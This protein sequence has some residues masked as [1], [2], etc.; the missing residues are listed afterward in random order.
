MINASIL[1]PK[2]VTVDA[3]GRKYIIRNGKPQNNQ[4]KTFFDNL[5][6]KKEYK[7]FVEDCIR[8]SE[9]K[10][11]D[12]LI[13]LTYD[14][15]LEWEK[16]NSEWIA[17]YGEEKYSLKESKL[18]Y[19]INGYIWG[20]ITLNDRLLSVA[21]SRMQTELELGMDD[22]I[23]K[24]SC[25]DMKQFNTKMEPRYAYVRI[26]MNKKKIK[27]YYSKTKEEYFAYSFD[28]SYEGIPVCKI[29][30]FKDYLSLR[31]EFNGLYLKPVSILAKYGYNVSSSLSASKRQAILKM[32]MDQNIMSWNQIIEHLQFL[33]NMHSGL[34][35][36]HAV[37]LWNEDY[38]FVLDY[39]KKK[40]NR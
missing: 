18:R 2:A 31:E 16:K 3:N 30:E 8:F 32:I 11:D 14:G 22:M 39:Y 38:E 37:E 27:V 25:K 23:V 26:G 9:I 17:E 7:Y 6:A 19:S 1:G 36:V 40:K 5:Y 20:N 24:C 21:I 13:E 15:I 12:Y 28:M 29:I 10:L 33:M 35:H 4:A 34:G